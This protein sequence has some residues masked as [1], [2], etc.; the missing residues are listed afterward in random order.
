[1]RGS[2]RSR[3]P[4]SWEV[5]YEARPDPKTGQRR[6]RYITVKGTKREAQRPLVELLHQV[7]IGTHCD[8]SKL[9]VADYLEQWLMDHARHRVS[10]KTL[11]RYIEIVHKHLIPALGSQRLVTL[12]PLQLRSYYSEALTKE[13]ARILRSGITVRLPPLAAQS[14]KHHHRVLSQALR[15]AVR[16]RLLQYNPCSDVDPPT[17]KRTEMKII[18]YGQSAEVIKAAKQRGCP[19]F[20]LAVLLAITTG[21]RRGELL[22]LRWRHLDLTARTLQVAQTLEETLAGLTFKEPKSE[23]SRRTVALDTLTVDELRRHRRQQAED[24]LRLG[25]RQSDDTLICC[26]F[27]GQPLRPRSV[28]KRFADLSRQLDLGV[29]FHDLRHSHISHLLAAGVHPK[30]ASERAG[31]AGV[32]ITLDIYSHVIPGMQEEAADRVGAM[33]RTH[34]ERET[35]IPVVSGG[36]PVANL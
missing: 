19:S 18:D 25:I 9:T 30:V 5:K 22:A 3:S 14:I 32:S 29:R 23:R 16:L 21:L 15:Q 2:I 8:L 4:G 11:E 35:Q 17:P 6:T 33:L 12:S 10:A 36:N 27:E 13:R 1:M 34:L 7:D 31:H 20:Y 28:T 26:D 24:L